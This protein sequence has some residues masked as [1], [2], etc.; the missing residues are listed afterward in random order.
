MDSSNVSLVGRLARDPVFFGDDN[1]RRALFT[2]ATSRQMG[3][4]KISI[5][6][7]CIAWG[8]RASQLD[9]LNKGDPV[10]VLGQFDNEKG[11]DDKYSQLRVLANSVARVSVTSKPETQVEDTADLP[12]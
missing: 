8:Y 6:V 5:F 3:D 12:F 11:K 10:V 1:K 9:G 4:K 2:V 7:N